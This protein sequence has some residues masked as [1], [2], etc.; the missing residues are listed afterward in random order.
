MSDLTAATILEIERLVKR[1]DTV[2]VETVSVLDPWTGK[3]VEFPVGSLG[4]SVVDVAAQ[5]GM[6]RTSPTRRRGVAQVETLE[7]FVDLVNRH[8]DADSAIFGMLR[9]AFP[10]LRAVID[11]HTLVKEPRFGDHHVVYQFPLSQEWQAWKAIDGKSMNQVQFSQWI[12]D[13]IH[14]FTTAEE[15]EVSEYENQLQLKF[16][17]PHDLARVSRGISIHADLKVESATTLATGESQLAFSEAH[18]VKGSD[19]KPIK[20]PGLMMVQIP[21]F[22]GGDLIRIAARLRYER[23]GGAVNWKFLMFRADRILLSALEDAFARACADTELPGFAGSP[24]M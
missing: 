14:E 7:S 18:T 17:S 22:Y 11:Y 9:G 3:E 1:G 24:E 5:L 6:W 12:E 4:G 23:V 20:I 19:A 8:K 21:L 2:D 13:H 15:G 10:H 16:G